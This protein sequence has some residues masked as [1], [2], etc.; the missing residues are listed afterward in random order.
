MF[1]VEFDKSYS[2][3]EEKLVKLRHDVPPDELSLPQLFLGENPNFK[4][5]CNAVELV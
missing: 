5:A 2:M 1:T 4:N 3:L